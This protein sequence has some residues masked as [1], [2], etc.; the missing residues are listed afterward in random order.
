[1]VY[2]RQPGASEDAELM[3]E[4]GKDGC[5]TDIAHKEQVDAEDPA[6]HGAPVGKLVV[7]QL[8]RHCPPDKQAGE[9]ATHGEEYLTRH[10][11]EPV[12][13]SAS[14]EAQPWYI[15]ERER[16]EDADKQ[17]ADGDE[18]GSRAA[19]D[20]QFLDEEGCAHLVERHERRDGC[21][22]QEGVEEH[23]HEHAH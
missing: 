22:R 8:A 20:M 1:M 7:H 12:E 15:A 19:R 9:E 11:V 13:E 2:L 6:R 14:A 17:A 10:K 16:T 23:R 4:D 5:G 18:G 21:Q 3:K